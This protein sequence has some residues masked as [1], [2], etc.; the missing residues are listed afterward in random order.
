[1]ANNWIQREVVRF[2]NERDC[3][4]ELYPVSAHEFSRLLL[5]IEDRHVNANR[6][7]DILNCMVDRGIDM[8]AARQY[9]GVADVSQADLRILI[10]QII[11]S[12]PLVAADIRAGNAKA[13]GSLIGQARNANPNANPSIIREMLHELLGLH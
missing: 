3:S 6:A 7:K 2:L 10:Q 12:N 11:T 9:L 13:I 5:A 8:E 4:I 1:L